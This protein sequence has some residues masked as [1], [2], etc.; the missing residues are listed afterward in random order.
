MEIG[1]DLNKIMV[2]L[3]QNNVDK[4]TKGLGKMGADQLKKLKI[5][6]GL[7]FEN[8]LSAATK[9]YGYTKTIFY[10][11]KNVPLYDFYINM[12]L[13]CK[14]LVI[15]TINV[16]N[17]IDNNNFV[18]I[19]GSGGLGKST[20]IKHFFINSI[21]NTD[22]I[23]IF[24]ELKILND[25]EISLIDCI[26]ESLSNLKF[27]LEKSYFEQSLNSG[28]YLI[29]LD[30]FDEVLDSKREILIQE[31]VALTDSYDDNH[32][33]LSS[34]RSDTLFNG[35][36]NSINY[37][38]VPLDKQK[39][40]TLINKL[41]YP[42]EI[43]GKFLYELEHNLFDLH[44]SFCSNPLLLNLMFLTYEEFAEIPGKV[45]V[46][47]ANAF[48]VLYSKHD[49]TKSFKRQHKTN[50]DI[51]YDEFVKVLYALSALSYMDS[52]I[53]FSYSELEEYINNSKKITKVNNFDTE[54]FVADIVESI[55]LFYL[56]GLKYNFQHRSFQEFFTAKFILKLPDKK[57]YA[58][59]SKLI[60]KR[61]DSLETDNV[62]NLI[63]EMEKE[64]FEKVF[65]IPK[66]KEIINS[67]QGQNES[68]THFNFLAT[69]FDSYQL[70][71]S[72]LGINDE[73]QKLEDCVSF[74]RVNSGNRKYY[75]EFINFLVGKYKNIYPH[76]EKPTYNQ[77]Y[78][79]IDI[80]EKFGSLNEIS[81]EIKVEFNKV[82]H[83]EELMKD[84]LEHSKINVMNYKFGEKLL[85]TLEK[86]HEET[87]NILGGLFGIEI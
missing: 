68:I 33:I 31:I 72:L 86:K 24:V 34:R 3:V 52:N 40:I 25:K 38:L 81:G 39:A 80:I 55:C 77:D 17:L 9:K 47:Y 71:R 14:D 37:D 15:D 4:I 56:D 44:N 61:F 5:K 82:P 20:L 48:T 23:P 76:I 12:D 45:H 83:N 66:L 64:K 11:D 49:A 73:F 84:L 63:I 21:I 29:L 32:F 67:L 7:A 22:Y 36:N 57:M 2:N 69:G 6:T 8:Y 26:Y 58:I 87:D 43:K 53:T 10:R 59:L 62:L 70:D 1:M 41:N 75:M 19:Y 79:R 42:S 60:E 74:T 54:D 16:S 18:T 27:D 65:L 50:R 13:K 78:R 46:F 85:L 30:G 51:G 28:R 35:W